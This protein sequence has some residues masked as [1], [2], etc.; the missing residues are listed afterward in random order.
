VPQATDMS[1]VTGFIPS[2]KT[3]FNVIATFL[4]VLIGWIFFR[5]EN[6]EDTGIIFH[7]IFTTL[8]HPQSISLK[9]TWLAAAAP[10]IGLLL[11]LEWST[12]QFPHPLHLLSKLPRII[13]W[14]VYTFLLWAALYFSP[15]ETGP[16][17]YFQF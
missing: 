6:W 12:R 3:V 8:L 1:C 13:R 4:F 10:R 9:G 2:V 7:Q 16:F 14:T 11:L 15:G 17:I 5:A